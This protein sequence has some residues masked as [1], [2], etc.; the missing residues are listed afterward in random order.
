MKRVAVVDY[1]AS[2][3][4]NVCRA[5]EHCGGE[6]QLVRGPEDLE[7]AERVVL[8]GVGA[9][10]AC[11]NELDRLRLVEP[12]R[13]IA[14]SGAPFL[15]IC[16]GMQV[17]F[18]ASEEFGEHAGLGLIAG[19]VVPVPRVA[20]D[21]QRLKV[22]HIGWP[23]LEFPAHRPPGTRSVLEGVG[24]VGSVYFVHGYHAFP[25]EAEALLATAQHGGHA[26]TAAVQVA[27][28]V[29]CQFHPERSG[30]VGLTIL[31][32]FLNV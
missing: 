11:M 22:P 32:R 31:R 13:K 26:I 8:P 10:R 12:L 17:M 19:R 25:K 23:R 18:D 3:I 21:G 9:F 2:N 5:L 30:E 7:R 14:A 20:I 1:G 28:L 27:N 6:V 4:L 16:L 15:G 24:E 29:G